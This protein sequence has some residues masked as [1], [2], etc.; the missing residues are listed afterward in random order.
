MVTATC[1]SGFPDID[2][3]NSPTSLYY[4]YH[5]C[6]MLVV[7]PYLFFCAGLVEIDLIQ[8]NINDA[9]YIFMLK[10]L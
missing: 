6:I 7:F 8:L 10:Y 2:M 1:A 4:Y 9:Q 5:L 3:I